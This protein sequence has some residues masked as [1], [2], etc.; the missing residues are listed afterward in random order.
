M[1]ASSV[2][3]QLKQQLELVSEDVAQEVLDFVL[4]VQSRRQEEDFLWQQVEETRKF[5]EQ[6]P[7]DVIVSTPEDWAKRTEHLADDEP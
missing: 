4:F 5:R 7:D 2:R 3:E 1:Q 6:H